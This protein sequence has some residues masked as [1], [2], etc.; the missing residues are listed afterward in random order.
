MALEQVTDL[1]PAKAHYYFC[2]PLGF[3]KA[4]RAQLLALGVQADRMHYEVFGPHQDL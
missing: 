4:I 2:G 3:M 1:I